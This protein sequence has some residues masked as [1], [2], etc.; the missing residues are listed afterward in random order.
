MVGGHAIDLFAPG[1]KLLLT[2]GS[3][4]MVP[5]K[6]SVCLAHRV[7]PQSILY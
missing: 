3:S 4:F 1:K 5:Y 2:N 7:F 6:P